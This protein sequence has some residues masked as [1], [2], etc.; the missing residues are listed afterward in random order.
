M[1]P[2]RA[3]II[4]GWELAES[5]VVERESRRVKKVNPRQTPVKSGWM[6]AGGGFSHC[7][8]APLAADGSRP[9]HRSQLLPLQH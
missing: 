5:N 8:A 2:L 6:R 9:L 3:S 7:G 1:L 4:G